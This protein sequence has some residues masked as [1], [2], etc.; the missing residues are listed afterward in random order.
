MFTITLIYVYK[1]IND[2]CVITNEVGTLADVLSVVKE[3]SAKV[4]KLTSVTNT[5][6]ELAA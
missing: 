5:E 3:A 2:K 1:S 6:L 4:I